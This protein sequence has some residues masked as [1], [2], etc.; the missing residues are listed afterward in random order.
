MNMLRVWGGGIYEDPYFYQLC[1]ELGIMVWQDFMFACGVYTEG[2]A[3]L[4]L[5]RTESESIISRLRNHCSL[6]IWCGNNE[7]EWI[8]YR[9]G[10]NK[11]EDMPGYRIFH[12]ILPE[13]CR[14][15]DPT[16]PYWPTTPWGGED[17][18][19]E[20]EGNRHSW[21]IWSRW[22]DFTEVVHDS[23]N[24]I[25]EFGF[26]APA[27]PTTLENCLEPVDRHPESQ[28]FAHHQKQE[29]GNE[30]L[31]R[32]LTAHHK[33]T[34]EFIPFIYACQINQ[35]EALKTCIEHWRSRKFD[36]AGT[37][38]WQLNDCWPA[39]SWSL[40]DCN[41]Q[42]KASYYYAR[43]FFD[44]PI[45]IFKEILGDL[46]IHVVN[47]LLDDINGGI[48]IKVLTFE[49]ESLLEKTLDGSIS[50]NSSHTLKAILKDELKGISKSSVYVR[51]WLSINNNE[52]A[53]ANYFFQRY[54]WIDFPKNSVQARIIENSGNE[55]VL[56][57]YSKSLLKSLFL[58]HPGWIFSD[59]FFDLNPDEPKQ[60]TGKKNDGAATK[61]N[62]TV[63]YS[64]GHYA[65][66]PIEW[67]Q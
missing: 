34:T 53:S 39:I 15:Q 66:Q 7:N 21:D 4:N 30:R 27:A 18:N 46:H 63:Y 25:S 60:L 64:V 1:D 42:P 51:A 29:E 33:V 28:R 38:I 44:S 58:Y 65:P 2:D 37:L 49:G 59:N 13:I 43:H 35:A 41:L 14:S 47:D 10:E 48:N 3:F 22:V 24:F 62:E 23:G 11:T 40:I 45:L 52:I 9:E 26:Q 19:C 8:W 56:E 20:T 31:F 55:V 17:P 54:K 57:C 6:V 32:F 12:D 61:I 36:T 16:R 67:K 5:V 50:A